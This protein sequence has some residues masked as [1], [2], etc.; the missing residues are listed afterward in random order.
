M[1]RQEFEEAIELVITREVE[2]RI[3]EAV[4]DDIYQFGFDTS[5]DDRPP[6]EVTR[7]IIDAFKSR[8]A[9]ASI[10]SIALSLIR[11]CID[12]GTVSYNNFD[13]E[14]NDNGFA[15]DSICLGNHWTDDDKQNISFEE[16]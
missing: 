2:T 11:H 6:V 16:T 13:N 14:L 9:D 12:N 1:L 7:H 5:H 15:G 4:A 10:A 3:C 8:L